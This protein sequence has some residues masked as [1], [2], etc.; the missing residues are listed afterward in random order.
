MT[1]GIITWTS[2]NGHVVLVLGSWFRNLIMFIFRAVSECLCH[3]FGQLRSE[4]PA[5][6]V[7]HSSVI[8]DGKPDVMVTNDKEMGDALMDQLMT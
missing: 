4:N 5:I 3:I 1:D 2:S 6:M 8:P 7:P